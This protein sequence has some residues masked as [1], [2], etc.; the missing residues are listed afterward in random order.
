MGSVGGGERI[1]KVEGEG[2]REREQGGN[3]G[4][5]GGRGK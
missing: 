5:E 1:A 2:E 4:R 3:G